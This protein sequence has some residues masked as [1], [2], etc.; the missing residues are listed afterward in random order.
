MH[1]FIKFTTNWSKTSKGFLDLTVSITESIIETDLYVKSSDSHQYL[2]PS[3]YHPFYC[4][5]GML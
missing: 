3:S 1:S 5:K 2:L 4:K